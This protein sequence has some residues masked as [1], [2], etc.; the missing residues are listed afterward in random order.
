[1]SALAKALGREVCSQASWQCAPRRSAR[2]GVGEKAQG[3]GACSSINF[4]RPGV[5]L[6]S[7][8]AAGSG[9]A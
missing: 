9:C 4:E 1:M 3:T 5:P 7:L 2:V 6:S 8:V